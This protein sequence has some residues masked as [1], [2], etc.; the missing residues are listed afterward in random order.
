M[1]FALGLPVTSVVKSLGKKR[2]SKESKHLSHLD[3]EWIL[4]QGFTYGI[5]DTECL[6][7][8]G[9]DGNDWY[10]RIS[11]WQ[12]KISWYYIT[13][14]KGIPRTIKHGY[15]TKEKFYELFS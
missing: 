11:I 15:M 1:L 8:K 5:F 3:E 6:W 10:V 13:E 9:R 2:E 12:R 14:V 7:K 4:S